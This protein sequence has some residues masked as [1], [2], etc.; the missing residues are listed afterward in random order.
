MKVYLIE[1]SRITTE[2]FLKVPELPVEFY[3]K[4][5]WEEET[6]SYIPKKK[7]KLFNRLPSVLKA[8]IKCIDQLRTIDNLLSKTDKL[9]IIAAAKLER[10]RD[11]IAIKSAKNPKN[12]S[13]SDGFILTHNGINFLIA[14]YMGI[15]F[16]YGLGIDHVCS[17]GND[18]LGIAY[19]MIKNKIVD[20]A[21][22]CGINS[23]A[24]VARTSYHKIL[25]V[26]SKKGKIMP[27]DK[28][29]DGTIFS[30]AIA[31]GVVCSERL[32]EK[33]SISPLLSIEG[34]NSLCDSYHMFSLDPSGE[35]FIK[36]L[37]NLTK[38]KAEIEFIKAHATA[39]PT[40]DKAEGK[41]YTK[42]F[43]NINV[44]ALKPLIGHSVTACGLA[45]LLILSD[46]LEKGKVPPVK[47]H[48][49]FDPECGKIN[50]IRK[51]ITYK[52][53]LF[54]SVSA[55]FGGFFSA[56]LAKGV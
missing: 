21:I 45:E 38:E 15:R 11:E 4:I 34:Y 13:P 23:M 54:I 36:L 1:G 40:N 29:R 33:M 31:L 14:N 49:E 19:K 16:Y 41:A 10:E 5:D 27:F 48:Q 26:V 22:V 50:V 8:L 20:A 46:Y 39:T 2:E 43:G 24:S 32:T 53:G 7:Y 18:V 9:A 56:L 51:E 6:S 17:S 3:G 37:E 25:R 35:S 30:D 47:N 52:K 12:V 44:T 55:G 42:L 28:E